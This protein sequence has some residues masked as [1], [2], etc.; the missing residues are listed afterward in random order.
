MESGPGGACAQW[1]APTRDCVVV[2]GCSRSAPAIREIQIETGVFDE[3]RTR[4]FRV[5]V[6]RSTTELRTPCFGG[7][8]WA[9][10]FERPTRA[11]Q[12]RCSTRLSYAQT[13]TSDGA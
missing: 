3:D 7:L 8:V 1:A 11:F 12:V 13:Q 5:T 10:R 9:E 6:G 2:V 4:V